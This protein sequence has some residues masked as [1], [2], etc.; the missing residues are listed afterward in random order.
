MS[1]LLQL[2]IPAVFGYLQYHGIDIRRTPW[3]LL[4]TSD[5]A[6]QYPVRMRVPFATWHDYLVVM[7]DYVHSVIQEE[8]EAYALMHTQF[9]V[10]PQPTLTP[11][12]A[13]DFIQAHFPAEGQLLK[14]PSASD[15]TSDH[16]SLL[17]L[18]KASAERRK[19]KGEVYN[20]CIVKWLFFLYYLLHKA[21][22][23][24]LSNE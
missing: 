13:V 17:Q 10:L 23:P 18:S 14:I 19:Y 2:P 22:Q 16:L 12:D 11:R 7:L 8:V 15:R 3:Q 20:S 6:L 1:F 9:C 4:S 24:Q 5:A 21:Y